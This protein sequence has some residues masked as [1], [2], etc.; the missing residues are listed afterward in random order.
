MIIGG[1]A[2]L[3]HGRPRTTEDIDIVVGADPSR[4]TDVLE[5]CSALHLSVLTTDVEP[6]VRQ[7][8]V[9]PAADDS[10]GI[11]I[12]FI[13]SSTA[14][15]KEAIKRAEIVVLESQPVPFCSAEDLIVLKLIAGRA[16]DLQDAASVVR[17]KASALDWDY[18][19]GWINRFSQIEGHENL[20]LRL[21][22]LRAAAE[23]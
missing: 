12:D 22:E 11:R 1:Q 6:F 20:T 14:F 18:L 23:H 17:R 13:F 16:V 2:V 7:S 9:L 4:L 8:F 10:T 19:T 21:D 3:L 15:E 5:V